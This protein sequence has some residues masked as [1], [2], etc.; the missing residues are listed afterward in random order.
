M[1]GTQ[2]SSPAANEFVL[3]G[4]FQKPFGLLGE[5]RVKPETFDFNRHQ[6]LTTVYF[7]KGTEAAPVPLKIGATRDD[8]M[9]WYLRFEGHRTPESV[10]H[11]SGGQLLIPESERLP[12]PE[13]MVYFSDMPGLKVV[14]ETGAEIGKVRE[15]LENAASELLLVDTQKGETL[16]PWN[17]HF[18]KKIDLPSQVVH[19]DM[20]QL[21]E[22][23]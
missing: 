2:P 18:V 16:I 6:H 13:N 8:G 9:F 3:I 23:L 5:I 10:S 11:L 4:Y 14:D 15:I 7:Q 12:L 20:T 21:R 22:L 19:V 17:E 1:S